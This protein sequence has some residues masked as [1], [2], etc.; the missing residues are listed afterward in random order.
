MTY[1]PELVG[2][3]DNKIIIK[4]SEKERNKGRKK[5]PNLVTTVVSSS[6]PTLNR[7]AVK[8]GFIKKDS[9]S[10]GRKAITQTKIN[11]MAHLAPHFSYVFRLK[12]ESLRDGLR[13]N[14]NSK[15]TVSSSCLN[16]KKGIWA[17]LF[18]P[19]DFWKPVTLVSL[20]SVLMTIR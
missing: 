7:A 17:T 10:H 14:N 9:L 5:R 12:L 18:W 13:G 16:L 2:K 3:I 15:Q 11:K 8:V 4:T 6:S 20:M 1:G 19:I